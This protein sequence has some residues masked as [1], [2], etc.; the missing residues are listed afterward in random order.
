MGGMA[1]SV[2]SAAGQ[3]AISPH[4]TAEAQRARFVALQ[5]RPIIKERNTDKL[6]MAL[7]VL[8]IAVSIW[9]VLLLPD[10]EL[11][12]DKLSQPKPATSEKTQVDRHG[13]PCA[14]TQFGNVLSFV[15]CQK[16]KKESK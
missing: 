9:F 13:Q 6:L 10:A 5:A 14:I 3:A 12:G 15:D 2:I 11:D 8:L 1:A 16:R 4:V 7:F